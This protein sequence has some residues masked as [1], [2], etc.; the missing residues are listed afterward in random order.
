TYPKQFLKV[1][2]EKSLLAKTIERFMELV[3]SK[4]IIVVTNSDYYYHV[5]AELEECKAHEAYVLNEPLAKNT[6]P[7]AVLA[8]R[9]CIDEIGCSLNEVLFIAP[10]DHI[11]EPQSK[12]AD[13]M[14]KILGFAKKDKIFT[15]GIKPNKPETGYGYIKSGEVW[16]IGCQIE[17]FV[18]KPNQKNA[19]KYFESG[20]YYWNSGMYIFN[21]NTFFK[22]LNDYQ[23][24]IYNLAISNSYSELLD[25]FSEMPNI[26][27]DYAIA[28]KSKEVVMVPIEL[29]W[30]DIGSWDAIYEVMN[31][32]ENGNVKSGDCLTLNCSNS[33]IMGNERL[34]IGI[35]MEDAIIVETDD[36]IVVAKKGESQKVKD[37]VEEIR[38]KGRKEADEHTIG[39]RP[40]GNY[41]IIVQGIGYK[42]KKITVLPGESI[43]LQMH[44]HR[45][46][47]WIVIKGIAKV[48]IND[49]DRLVRENE[50]IYINKC[51]RHRLENPGKLPLEI[52]E[53]QNGSY[54]SEDDIIRFEEVCD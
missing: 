36:V 53:V 11:I 48:T 35:G 27:L 22:E 44:Q 54:I 12:F 19:Q 31:K 20:N 42:V 30:N 21:I 17:K 32:D 10:A 5:K 33:L 28:E 25:K 2:C 39:Y 6:A 7:A 40:W 34:V 41:K 37:I 13:D 4:D 26:S 29:D 43:S 46:E 51:T 8:A 1:G 3:P 47:H 52:I 16:E 14:K 18:E 9:Y 50:S 38:E 24:D 45:S 15:L 49:E 23:P